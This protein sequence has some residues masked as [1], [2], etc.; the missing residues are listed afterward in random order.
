V[1]SLSPHA[2]SAVMEGWNK[3][4]WLDGLLRYAR[5]NLMTAAQAAKMDEWAIYQCMGPD[6]VGYLLSPLDG[7]VG[8][9]Y[10]QTFAQVRDAALKTSTGADRDKVF[11][12]VIATFLEGRIRPE[13]E[14]APAIDP[15]G[16]EVSLNALFDTSDSEID[17]QSTIQLNGNLRS[18]Y[19]TLFKTLQDG[20]GA[21]HV[22]CYL[23]RAKTGDA[24]HGEVSF[25]FDLKNNPDRLFYGFIKTFQ[26]G[27]G[28]TD[29][30]KRLTIQDVDPVICHDVFD[31]MGRSADPRTHKCGC[32]TLRT[33]EFWLAAA[34]Q[35]HP[36]DSSA[37]SQ[38]ATPAASFACAKG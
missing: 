4:L 17:S 27:D 8:P 6:F 30:I 21:G 32:G 38:P 19:Q 15:Q 16:V 12:D 20:G 25:L 11:N 2:V 34:C 37:T 3:A 23:N 24:S 29:R 14:G 33:W 7:T 35:A 36:D 5:E 31:G 18:R 13:F 1:L 26:A 22:A 28:P 10:H 9:F